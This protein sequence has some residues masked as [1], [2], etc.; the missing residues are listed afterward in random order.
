MTFAI[1]KRLDVKNERGRRYILLFWHLNALI[2]IYRFFFPN[3]DSFFFIIF[4][5]FR[6]YVTTINYILSY[7]DLSKC[8]Y[9]RI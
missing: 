7:R 3:S 9:L 8:N 5:Y 1:L 4:D 6:T 2:A